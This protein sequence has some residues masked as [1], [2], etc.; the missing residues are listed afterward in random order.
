MTAF[1]NPE[2][3]TKVGAKDAREGW[4]WWVHEY[5][6]R[7]VQMITAGLNCQVMWP[8]RMVHGD[9]TQ[10]YDILDWAGL[11]WKSEVFNF[12]DPML[13]NTRQKEKEGE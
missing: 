9:Y 13:W 1:T 11:K 5:E 7:F 2:N 4:L 3:Q 10:L 12:I 6:K 8:Q